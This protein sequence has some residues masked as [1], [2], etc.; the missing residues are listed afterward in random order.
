MEIRFGKSTGDITVGDITVGD[1]TVG[2]KLTE[3]ILYYKKSGTCSAFFIINFL[4]IF[5]CNL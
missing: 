4:T 1:K 3:V 5:L 2:N